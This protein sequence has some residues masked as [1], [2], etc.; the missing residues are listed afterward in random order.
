MRRRIEFFEI[1]EGKEGKKPPQDS[2][3]YYLFRY[4]LVGDNHVGKTKFFSTLLGVTKKEAEDLRVGYKQ[5][6]N[7][8]N[9]K[10]IK[11]E[12]S[13]FP[14]ECNDILTMNNAYLQKK[15]AMFIFFDINNYYS[16]YPGKEREQY[17]VE[18]WHEEMMYHN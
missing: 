17:G 9:K 5:Y 8:F 16:F 2:K 1:K 18:H 15:T 7:L 13:D 12:I 6:H 3:D 14:E 4:I 11:I 10:A